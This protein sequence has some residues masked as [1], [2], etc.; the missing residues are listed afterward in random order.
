MQ[1]TDQALIGDHSWESRVMNYPVPFAV[2]FGDVTD[3]AM[4]KT[5][6]GLIDW[7][8]QDCVGQVRLPASTV[9]AEV[10]SLSIV[11]ARAAGA[12]SLVVGAA[13]IGGGVPDNWLPSLREAA[14][15][16]I[17][18]VAGLHIRLASLPGLSEAAH[19]GGARLI[20]VRVPPPDLPIGTARKRTGRRVLTVGTDCA[21]GKKYAALALNQALRDVGADSTFRATGQ[22]GILIAGGGMPIDAVVADFVVG[23]AEEL[24]P[25][26]A[27]DHW[28]VIEGQGSIFH[29]AYLQVTIGL[30]IGS[31]PD[32]FVV[33]HD[34][35]RKHLTGW[36]AFAPPPIGDV[37]Q[38]TIEIGKLTS[39]TIRCVGV[40]LNTS[41]V[42]QKDRAALLQSYTESLGLP[43][44]DPMIDG[45]RPVAERLTAEFPHQ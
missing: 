28:D 39:P 10:P 23:A 20:D 4:A 21:V 45:M 17:H 2:F 9:K 26:A 12:R 27:P 41:R 36:P 5:G 11:E 3:E 6:L 43:C 13:F 19:A 38:R 8:R 37:I 32:A 35:L 33:C 34:P 15:A 14:A 29:P 22:T 24:S 30:L 44:V 40:A 18:I 31:Q 25:D 42:P 7:R 1:F 16:G